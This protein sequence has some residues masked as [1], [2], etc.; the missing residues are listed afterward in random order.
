MRRS[1]GS[2]AGAGPL[3]AARARVSLKTRGEPAAVAGGG[4]PKSPA[5]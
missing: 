1:A 4:L 5:P 2:T 3:V